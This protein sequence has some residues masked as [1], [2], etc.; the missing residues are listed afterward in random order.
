MLLATSDPLV[1]NYTSSH[2]GCRILRCLAQLPT[3]VPKWPHRE[4]PKC[5]VLCLI[6][7]LS[8]L[9]TNHGY[10]LPHLSSQLHAPSTSRLSNSIT[11]I[12]DVRSRPDPSIGVRT[13]PRFDNNQRHQPSAF[14]QQASTRPTH[15][16][17]NVSYIW[18]SSYSDL[19]IAATRTKAALDSNEL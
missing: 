18:N 3:L 15:V 13:I 8:R 4:L 5:C 17:G 19:D 12:L 11:S 2:Y 6:S 16:H 7:C 14:Y 9:L 1:T 10:D